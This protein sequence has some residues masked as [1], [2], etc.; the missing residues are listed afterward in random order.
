MTEIEQ[1]LLNEMKS[2]DHI[3]NLTYDDIDGEMIDAVMDGQ[4]VSIFSDPYE[5]EM[6]DEDDE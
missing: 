5:E 4:T 6:E 3:D 1:M 2:E